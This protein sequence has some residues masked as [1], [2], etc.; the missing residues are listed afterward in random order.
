MGKPDALS[1]HA[2]H[3]DGSRDNK[4]ITL[5]QL[6]LFAICAVKGLTVEGEEQ[7]I[8]RDICHGNQA[9]AQEDAV[10]TAVTS[11]AALYTM[12]TCI[13]CIQGSH[14]TTPFADRPMT[15]RQCSLYPPS[16]IV[17]WRSSIDFADHQPRTGRP[18]DH[19]RLSKLIPFLPICY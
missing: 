17:A 16:Y 4:D 18:T 5:L 7:D 10:A 19:Y 11:R 1:Q 3:G 2:D 9:G 14:K 8:L 12:E 13:Q 15:L 6:E